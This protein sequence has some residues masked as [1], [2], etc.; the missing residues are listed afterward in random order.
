LAYLAREFNKSI[1]QIESKL[2]IHLQEN[3]DI[4]R[5]GQAEITDT[6]KKVDDNLRKVDENQTRIADLLLQITHK[7]KGP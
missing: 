5:R 7:G 6:L 4:T 3:Y 1:N 2:V